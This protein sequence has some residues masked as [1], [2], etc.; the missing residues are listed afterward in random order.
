MENNSKQKKVNNIL[1]AFLKGEKLTVVS[2]LKKYR[3]HKLSSRVSEF[4][5]K[6]HIPIIGTWEEKNKE[7]YMFYKLGKISQEKRK[8]LEVYLKLK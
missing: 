2:A 8:A 4:R 7:K 5:H 6:L 1:R 3:T